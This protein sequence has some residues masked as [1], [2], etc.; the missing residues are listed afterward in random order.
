MRR[1]A[2]SILS[3]GKGD[4]NVFTCAQRKQPRPIGLV[5]WYWVVAQTEIRVGTNLKLEGE[6]VVVLDIYHT[7]TALRYKLAF[8]T[9][10][11]GYK[12]KH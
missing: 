1:V 7:C 10:S 11:Q 4:Y 6:Y 12:G 9:T 5:A 2:G 3:R 8:M